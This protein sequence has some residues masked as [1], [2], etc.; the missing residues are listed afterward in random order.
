MIKPKLGAL[1]DP[2]DERDYQ[3]K[4]FLKAKTV[5]LPSSVDKSTSALTV[6]NQENEGSCVSFATTAA[7]EY[8]EGLNSPYLSPRFIADRI[9]LDADSGAYPRD[10]MDVLLKE[11]VCPEE[12]Q[13]YIARVHTDPCLRSGELAKENKIKAYARLNTLDEMKQYL[14]ERG[15]FMASFQVTNE[16]Y[17]PLNGLIVPQGPRIGGH[18]VCIVGYDDVRQVIKFR[19]SWGRGWGANG[20]GYLP[21]ISVGQYLM[22]AWS[23][24]DVPEVE[25]EKPSPE[26]QPTPEPQKN[27]ISLLLQFILRLFRR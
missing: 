9:Q 21:Y 19:N 5:V 2:K 16:W 22:D 23:M 3:I 4:S 17:T 8:D 24:V 25:E 26:P 27:W 7:K 13:P 12:C 11:G 1:K 20:Y 18:A 15:P 14:Y 10:A 6:R